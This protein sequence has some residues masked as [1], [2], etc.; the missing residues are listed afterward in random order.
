[1][2]SPENYPFLPLEVLHIRMK[3]EQAS[4]GMT[5]SDGNELND[6]FDALAA[7]CDGEQLFVGGSLASG[8]VYAPLKP[9]SSE[10]QQ[11]LRQLILWQ[12][13][14][15]GCQ[16]ELRPLSSLHSTSEKVACLE[17]FSQAQR[18][19]AEKLAEGADALASLAPAS[20]RSWRASVIHG[21]GMLLLEHSQLQVSLMLVRLDADHD[22]HLDKPINEFAAFNKKTLALSDIGAFIPDWLDL[23]WSRV[24]QKAG[25]QQSVGQWQ[26][27]GHGFQLWMMATSGAQLTHREVMLRWMS[28]VGA[29]DLHPDPSPK[30]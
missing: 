26:A 13:G 28:A 27:Q 19:L 14:I 24:P 17:A 18:Y 2:N 29:T 7:W 1:M 4:D 8:V 5:I 3:V 15:T 20:P 9:I 21:G 25:A 6:A 10:Q 12:P 16:M 30:A 11:G 23:H 22:S